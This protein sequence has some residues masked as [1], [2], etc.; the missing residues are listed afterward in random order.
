MTWRVGLAEGLTSVGERSPAPRSFG[1]FVS[2]TTGIS[3]RNRT[4][5][6]AGDRKRLAFVPGRGGSGAGS[7]RRG[8]PGG[9][10]EAALY[11]VTSSADLCGPGRGGLASEMVFRG[12]VEEEHVGPLD[13]RPIHR[14][15]SE[16]PEAGFPTDR[17]L[18]RALLQRTP[19]L[20][21]QPLY[22]L[23]ECGHGLLHLLT[24]HRDPHPVGVNLNQVV[25]ADAHPD[26]PQVV[27]SVAPRREGPQTDLVP[28]A[29]VL[30]LDAVSLI[31]LGARD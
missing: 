8:R 11:L 10:G 13:L 26:L 18:L 28:A 19:L 6:A 23:G 16:E 12:P 30:K 17:D 5:N 7:P 20:F 31:D 22:G 27:L 24:A 3:R 25:P 1:P 21:V 14:Q 2:D 15:C 29:R 4:L 9:Q